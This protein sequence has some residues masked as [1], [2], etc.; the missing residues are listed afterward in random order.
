MLLFLEWGSA[1]E[2]AKP[3]AARI[4]V[5]H[6]AVASVVSRW[7]SLV[8]QGDSGNW[9]AVLNALPPNQRSGW[10]LDEPKANLLRIYF[11]GEISA[12]RKMILVYRAADGTSLARIYGVRW[13]DLGRGEKR[14]PSC[15]RVLLGTMIQQANGPWVVDLVRR[16]DRPFGVGAS[17]EGIRLV[18]SPAQQ[19]VKSWEDVRLSIAL[20]NTRRLGTVALGPRPA[21]YLQWNT[22]LGL[23][24]AAPPS[25]KRPFREWYKKV[26]SMRSPPVSGLFE[27]LDA[28]QK[29]LILKPGERQ[30]RQFVLRRLCW[31]GD[32]FPEGPSGTFDLIFVYDANLEWDSVAAALPTWSHRVASNTFRVT[33]EGTEP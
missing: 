10:F 22:A 9:N 2:A 31:E 6:D 32:S 13:Q 26:E 14:V 1:G 21:F 7:N 16:D 18:A 29:P 5:A 12:E 23:V 28:R 20:E 24:K 8:E 15:R 33:V 25:A 4:V 11:D 17:V 27:D 30:E 3:G 19:H